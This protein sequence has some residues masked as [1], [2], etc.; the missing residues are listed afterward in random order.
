M[1]RGSEGSGR[2]DPRPSDRVPASHGSNEGAGKRTVEPQ[3]TARYPPVNQ[4]AKAADG[5]ARGDRSGCP[6]VAAPTN[7]V[8]AARIEAHGGHFGQI[9]SACLREAKRAGRDQQRS[10]HPPPIFRYTESHQAICPIR[11]LLRS[12]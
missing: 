2:L 12:L 6:P 1:R 11:L 8:P 9:D 3:P 7:A 10:S 5:G 4:A